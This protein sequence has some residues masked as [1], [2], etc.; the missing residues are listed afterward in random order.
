M[1]ATYFY[2]ALRFPYYSKTP[3][4]RTPSLSESSLQRTMYVVP[5]ILIPI[6]VI[7]VNWNPLEGFRL[8][9]GS[10]YCKY[11]LAENWLGITGAG[12]F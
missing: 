5:N 3:L 7:L 8:K 9:G 2:Q 10:L 11:M 1:T 6:K 4:N 12:R